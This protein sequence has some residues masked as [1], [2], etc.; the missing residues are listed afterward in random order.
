MH[1]NMP[2]GVLQNMQFGPRGPMGPEM[3]GMS[4]IGAMHG[5]RG[6]GSGPQGPGGPGMPP[7]TGTG[8]SPHSQSG[9]RPGGPG[10]PPHLGPPGHLMPPPH[11]IQLEMQ[12]IHQQLNH[13]FS[14]NPQQNPQIQQQVLKNSTYSCAG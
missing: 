11:P 2:P 8:S 12:H 6:P 7:H 3:R 1:P 14:Q 9:P 13:L 4:P 10:M 5:P